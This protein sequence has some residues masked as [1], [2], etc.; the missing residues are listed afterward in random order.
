MTNAPTIETERLILRAHRKDDY[1]ALA[2]MWAESQ[3][4]Q[5]ILGRPATAE[6]SW[7]RLLRYAG[8]WSLMGFGF[9]A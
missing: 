8:H 7:H 3:V 4:G 5:F 9:W 2:A 1:L 6:E